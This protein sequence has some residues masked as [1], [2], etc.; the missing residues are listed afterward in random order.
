MSK[1]FLKCLKK[2]ILLIECYWVLWWQ[3][4]WWHKQLVV[5][6]FTTD[7]R[8]EKKYFLQNKSISNGIHFH[9]LQKMW[10][11]IIRYSSN[12]CL[13][14]FADFHVYDIDDE[15]EY[16][17][18]YVSLNVLLLFFLLRSRKAKNKPRSCHFYGSNN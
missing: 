14:L 3:L 6:W 15:L 13:F 18:L 10:N 11:W 1:L 4:E 5:C 17:I 12:D 2:V 8:E 9:S 16:M 7:R